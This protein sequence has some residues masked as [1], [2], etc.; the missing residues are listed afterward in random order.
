MR[1]LKDIKYNWLLPLVFKLRRKRIFN[2][3]P[4]DL[5]EPELLFI[6]GSGRNGST[7]LARLLNQHSEVFLPP[8]QYALP[9]TIAKS[10][11]NYSGDWNSYLQSQINLYQKHNQHWQWDISD[12]SRL[13]EEA[14]SLE[15]QYQN[16]ANLFRLVLKNYA[17]KFKNGFRFSGDHS[18]ISTEFYPYISASFPQAHYIFLVRHPFDVILSY[19]KLKD[20]KSQAWQK[21]ARKWRNSIKAYERLEAENRKVLLVRYEDLVSDI[22][23]QLRRIFEFLELDPLRWSAEAPKQKEQDNLGARD[24]DYHQNLYKPVNASAIDQWKEKLDPEIVERLKPTLANQAQKFN[25][26]LDA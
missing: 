5:T 24:Y 21:A 3:A 8:E 11:F 6:M 26:S 9:Y 1:L 23:P 22:E 7:L 16:P 10:F 17:K 18:P 20:N 19:A 4:K 2:R 14:S 25:Y 15:A 13:K 12:L